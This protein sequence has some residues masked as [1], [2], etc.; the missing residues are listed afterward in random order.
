MLE[1]IFYIFVRFEV[2]NNF[3]IFYLNLREI[4]NFPE[5]N[6]TNSGLFLKLYFIIMLKSSI[7]NE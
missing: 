3:F 5:K 4:R 2:V 6:K 1:N 7:W